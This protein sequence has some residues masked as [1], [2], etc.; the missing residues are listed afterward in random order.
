MDGSKPSK[1]NIQPS[2]M[3]DDVWS[4]IMLGGPEPANTKIPKETLEKMRKELEYFYP[5]DLRTSAKDLINNHLTFFIYNHV[6]I[7]PKK[8][9]PK[10]VR[11]NGY[12][13][14]NN[15]KM[16][17]S[18]GNFMNMC[19]SLEKYGAD[20]T[21]FALADA[22]DGLDDANFVEKTADDAVLKLYT[23][24]E[25]L[26]DTL[27][28]TTLRTG[29]YTWND[30]VFDA[31][32]NALVQQA[33]KA[34]D[35]MLYR[36][37]LKVAYYDLQNARNEYRKVC[38]GQGLGLDNETWDGM[39]HDL[40]KKFA[41]LQA[42]LMCPILPHWSDYIWTE[43][44]KNPSTIINERF[45]TVE[46][47]DESILAA[48]RY[49]RNLTSNIRSA[50]EMA[51]KKK[52]KKATTADENQGPV[53]LDIYVAQ[54]FPDWQKTCMD[55]V[56]STWTAENGFDGTEIQ[57]LKEAGLLKNKKAMPFVAMIKK[58][59]QERGPEA[60]DRTL[61]FNERETL[62]LNLDLLRREL[63]KLKIAKVEVK[64]TQQAATDISSKVELSEPGA[65]AFFTV[66]NE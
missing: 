35:Q 5:L 31:E 52:K 55:L 48:S 63:S 19:D 16:S 25:W 51:S 28:S 7:F 61:V 65:P 30:K 6:A 9:W 39:H 2:D 22:G 4:Y 34:Y 60:F 53:K 32:L 11:V 38:T 18:T 27:K 21:R 56:K 29:E 40:I 46:S 43:I 66:P 49:I 37:V 54:E 50:D 20:A 13:L 3:T 58:S 64:D 12:L 59:V 15:E 17:K 23:E 44:L 41:S 62:N 24:L 42:L 36:E 47:V 45:P 10:G 8:H 57:K 1:Y 14:L 26:R 33:K